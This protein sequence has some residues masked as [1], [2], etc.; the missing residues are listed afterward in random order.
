MSTLPPSDQEHSSTSLWLAQIEALIFA[1]PKPLSLKELRELLEWPSTP[2]QQRRLEGL[3]QKLQKI[4]RERDGGFSLVYVEDEDGYQ[5]Q[6]AEKF[7]ELLER[8]LAQRPRP[9]S[10]AAHETLAIVA[11]RQPDTRADVEFVR[12]VDAGGMIK[13]LLEKNLIYCSGRKDHIPGKPMQ[14]STT[15]EFLKVYQMSAINQLPALESFQ[16]RQDT[17]QLASKPLDTPAVPTEG[18]EPNVYEENP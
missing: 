4:Y 14:F 2:D 3:C 8:M 18:K 12:G 13:N 1:S 5:F 9:L 6:T 7:Q 11:Y 16:P 17:V 10:R 15:R